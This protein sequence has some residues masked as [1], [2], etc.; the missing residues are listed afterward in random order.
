MVNAITGESWKAETTATELNYPD[1]AM[2]LVSNATYLTRLELIGA[3]APVDESFFFL[4]DEGRRSEAVRVTN[5]LMKSHQNVKHSRCTLG[6]LMV[7]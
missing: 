7:N 5:L 1:E 4:L 6:M 2:Q 3:E